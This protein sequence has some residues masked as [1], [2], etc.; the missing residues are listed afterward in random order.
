V[1]LAVIRT[2]SDLEFAE[3][4]PNK[5]SY[6]ASGLIEVN[7][8]AAAYNLSSLPGTARPASGWSPWPLA[9]GMP[10]PCMAGMCFVSWTRMAPAVYGWSISQ[11]SPKPVPFPVLVPGLVPNTTRVPVLVPPAPS[12]APVPVRDPRPAPGRPG[13]PGPVVVTGA[14][15]GVGALVWWAAKVLSP[16]CGPAVLVCAVAL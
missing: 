14:A 15:V 6:V 2:N 4:K 9:G 16:L 10:S 13:V 7:G 1:D 5:F 8:Y 12:P 3:V 11:M